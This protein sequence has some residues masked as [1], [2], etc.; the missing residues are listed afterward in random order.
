M[1]NKN[2]FWNHSLSYFP[3]NVRVEKTPSPNNP[4]PEQL[5]LFNIN[6]CQH[7]EIK[8]YVGFRE[9]YKYCT[10][11]DKKFTNKN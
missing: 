3:D 8:N 10:K 7:P 2:H 1:R 6:K 4:K 5:S 9:A 11:C